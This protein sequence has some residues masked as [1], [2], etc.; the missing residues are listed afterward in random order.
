MV[1]AMK[2]LADSRAGCEVICTGGFLVMTVM[3]RFGLLKASVATMGL[4]C[5]LALT[6]PAHGQFGEAAGISEAMQPEYFRRDIKT[7]ND[8]LK[9]DS[10][11][12]VIVEALF[13]DYESEFQAGLERMKKR[14][15]NMREE[16]QVGDQRRILAKVFAPFKDWTV[17]KGHLGEQ[18]MQSVKVVLTDEQL[19]LWP[20]VERR[21]YREK[22]LARPN[23]L[24]GESLNL[25][26]VIRDM[27]LDERTQLQ[28][29]P[30]ME[31]YDVA[32]DQALHRR[33]DP[34]TSV[35]N[36][37]LDAMADQDSQKRMN[38]VDRFIQLKIG[39]RSV[40]DEYIERIAAALPDEIGRQFR[41]QALERGYPRVYREHAV[42][43][44][45]KQAKEI[46]GLPSDVL[47][48]IVDLEAAFLGE[49][50][51]TNQ[52]LLNAVR[53]YEPLL[54]RYRAEDFDRRTSGQPT[55]PRND[56]TNAMFAQRDEMCRKYAK[57]LQG[58]LT[59]DQFAM[60]PGGFRWVEDPQALIEKQAQQPSKEQ[61]RTK[62]KRADSLDE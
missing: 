61:T 37:M 13:G 28:I 5:L 41:Q 53:Q 19:A 12:R 55:E 32:L 1:H 50:A 20:S 24:S 2:R 45:F 22:K 54:E 27:H 48:A 58:L 35:Q 49:L 17:E 57:R 15:E 4:S 59:P 30:V 42:Q 40:N 33:E 43:R 51:S 18:F 9:L 7:L 46:E 38:A 36:D 23:G 3:Q 29:Q 10:T 47:R 52:E 6:A 25:F 14:F 44:M 39:V 8:G 60:I 11:Q 21:L 56:P 16:L 62:S 26:Y 31:A 34:A